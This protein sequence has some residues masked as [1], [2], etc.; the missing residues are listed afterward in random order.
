MI[1]RSVRRRRS[2]REG[3]KKKVGEPTNNPIFNKANTKT[4]RKHV[5]LKRRQ[6]KPDFKMSF[7]DRKK[8]HK[9][10]KRQNKTLATQPGV[11]V[12]LR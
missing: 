3:E 10:H 8:K 4:Q 1:K 2:E 11:T 7:C 5:E 9:T 12:T 6:Q